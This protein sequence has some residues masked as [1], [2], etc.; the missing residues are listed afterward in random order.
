MVSE[1]PG[2]RACVGYLLGTL[3]VPIGPNGIKN[4]K[5]HCDGG[6]LLGKDT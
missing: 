5:E 4:V 1:K 2:C 3:F 6:W